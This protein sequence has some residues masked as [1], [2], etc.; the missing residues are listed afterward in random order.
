MAINIGYDPVGLSA[1]ASLVI[2]EAARADEERRRSEA[3]GGANMQTALAALNANAD[4]GA[5]NMLARGYSGGQFIN[6]GGGGGGNP[7]EATSARIARQIGG[8]N[9]TPQERAN[10]QADILAGRDPNGEDGGGRRGSGR[11]SA[12][13]ISST[14]GSLAEAQAYDFDRTPQSVRRALYSPEDAASIDR[15]ET[16]VQG[17]QDLERLQQS[18]R[19]DVQGAIYDRQAV[20]MGL[21]TRADEV[22]R[23]QL[24]SQLSSLQADD[25]IPDDIK[26]AHSAYLQTEIDKIPTT[27]PLDWDAD[28]KRYMSTLPDGGV[29]VRKDSPFEYKPPRNKGAEDSV[30]QK[31]VLSTT[32]AMGTD[33]K[34]EGEAIIDEQIANADAIGQLLKDMD[35]TKDPQALQQN[36]AQLLQ[37]SARLRERAATLKPPSPEAVAAKI[38]GDQKFNQ[39]VQEILKGGGAQQPAAMAPEAQAV[40]QKFAALQQQL[41]PKWPQAETNLRAMMQRAKD[42]YAAKDAQEVQAIQN[43]MALYINNLENGMEP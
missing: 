38:A 41:G 21:P 32:K 42:A 11:G 43:A 27:A 4:R 37:E 8:V 10:I 30:T 1:L 36:M 18:G 16:Q 24:Q 7:A 5:G 9:A 2:G 33:Y 15:I 6:L 25:T 34:D 19:M 29:L 13:P 35:K 31:E 17:Y 20:K 22:R 28:K 23:S 3:Q 12:A 39:R 14:L 26:S 40:N